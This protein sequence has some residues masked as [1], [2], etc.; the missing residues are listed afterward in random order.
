MLGLKLITSSPY[1]VADCNDM[2]RNE[3]QNF[4]KSMSTT[5]YNILQTAILKTLFRI[6]LFHQQNKK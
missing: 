2:S 1:S 3:L 5:V 4:P 6:V